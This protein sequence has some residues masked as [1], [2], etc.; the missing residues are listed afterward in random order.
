MKL[1]S[2]GGGVAYNFSKLRAR[3]EAIKNIDGRASG[4]MPVLKIMEDVFS[5]ANQPT[6]V[7]KQN[8]K[9]AKSTKSF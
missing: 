5:Y 3:G 1:S 8:T 6:W 2:I 7:A 9:L 4:V